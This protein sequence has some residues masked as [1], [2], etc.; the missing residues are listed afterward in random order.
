MILAQK[1]G[2]S[3]PRPENRP[4]VALREQAGREASEGTER[5]ITTVM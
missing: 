1:G 4:D 3:S 2:R 5:M